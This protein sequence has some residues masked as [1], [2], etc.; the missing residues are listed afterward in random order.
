MRSKN[1]GFLPIQWLCFALVKPHAP[2]LFMAYLIIFRGKTL[3][4]LAPSLGIYFHVYDYYL[5][6]KLYNSS[7]V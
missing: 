7:P 5:L 4:A 6:I 3:P 1:S 2:L